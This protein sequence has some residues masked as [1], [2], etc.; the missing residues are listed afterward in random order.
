MPVGSDTG[1]AQDATLQAIIL[2]LGGPVVGMPNG[3]GTGAAQDASLQQ[4]LA[5]TAVAQPNPILIGTYGDSNMQSGVCNG[6]PR[7]Q[8]QNQLRQSRGDVRFIG[9]QSVGDGGVYVMQQWNTDGIGGQTIEGLT[10]ALPGMIAAEGQPDL[11]I[12]SIGTNDF[13]LT[14]AQMQTAIEAMVAQANASAPR[15]RKLLSTI[16]V[17]LDEGA[18]VIATFQAFNAWLPGYVATLG[19]LWSFVNAFGTIAAD[20]LSVGLHLIQNGANTVGA[21]LADA[22]NALFPAKN[23]RSFPR[24]YAPEPGAYVL[25]L[26]AT[27]DYF[28]AGTG[29]AGVTAP[30]TGEN[31]CYT[32]RQLVEAPG[33]G[34]MFMMQ[35]TDGGSQLIVEMNGGGAGTVKVI[36]GGV[37]Q[38]VTSL[39]RFYQFGVWQKWQLHFDATSLILSFWINGMLI[40]TATLGGAIVFTTACN[41]Y[42]G[43]ALAAGF[44]G[45]VANCRMS[46]GASVPSFS[47]TSEAI[48]PYLE[49]DC[50]EDQD[51]PGIVF[52]FPLNN[53]LVD[54]MA[55][56]TGALNGAPTFVTNGP[57]QPQDF[58]PAQPPGPSSPIVVASANIVLTEAQAAGRLQIVGST[59]ASITITVPDGV[60]D[61]DVDAT[62]WVPGGFT[63][64]WQYA[65][66]T[67]TYAMTTAV[68]AQLRGNGL[69]KL[70]GFLG[71]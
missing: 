56:A 21:I 50:F 53:S 66:T 42:W 48:A 43:G 39:G 36:T 49:A 47:A 64:T 24:S 57:A 34:A 33:A 12:I 3:S 30:T 16:V 70:Y 7:L 69:S 65:T 32:W 62:L 63:I 35:V 14:L 5:L 8:L 60:L 19:P 10:A 4:I 6:G 40:G 31:F 52:D 9:T 20:G 41:T 25:R 27:S 11:M 61:L 71:A 18:G 15:S 13:G 68:C 17:R 46:T 59:G 2:A 55:A 1:G 28:Y 29:I 23:G 54:S 44:L 22:V 45:Y 38:I 26:N 51:V 37:A 67:K 58:Q